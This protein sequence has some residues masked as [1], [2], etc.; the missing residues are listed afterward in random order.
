MHL[1][2]W[3]SQSM[4]ICSILWST[5][6]QLT[7]EELLTTMGLFNLGKSKDSGVEE[8]IPETTRRLRDLIQDYDIGHRSNL[9]NKKR[10]NLT[11]NTAK[12]TILWMIVCIAGNVIQVRNISIQ[13]FRFGIES[14]VQ[15]VVE[16]KIAT[17]SI[18]LCF[19]VPYILK[20][21]E[22]THEDRLAILKF[23][24]LGDQVKTNILDEYQVDN[25]TVKSV[26]ELPQMVKDQADIALK[27]MMTA[28]LQSFD[29]SWIFNHTHRLDDLLK[30]GLLYTEHWPD[31]EGESSHVHVLMASRFQKFKQ[32]FKKLKPSPNTNT[33]NVTKKVSK[34]SNKYEKPI[35]ASIDQLVNVT[36]FFKDVL[37]C[38]NLNMKKEFRDF[39]YYQVMRQATV[40]G[41]LSLF[42]LNQARLKDTREL[43]YVLTP[44][45]RMMKSGFYSFSALSIE[46]MRQF[47][48]TW[49]TYEAELLEAPF[50]TE[51]LDYK[52]ATGFQSKGDCFETCFR[53]YTMNEEIFNET[54]RT[55]NGPNILE[56]EDVR[57]V[58]VGS[59]CHDKKVQS[60]RR[61][62]ELSCNRKCSAKDCLSIV[63][64]PK[65]LS[66]RKTPKHTT[67]VTLAPQTP[68]V[69]AF[70]VPSMSLTNYLTDV[71][72]TFGFWMGISAF[73]FFRSLKF[74]SNT[75]T[76]AYLIDPE[77]LKRR[78]RKRKARLPNMRVPYKDR[79][80]A[81]NPYETSNS[82]D[83]L[84]LKYVIGLQNKSQSHFNY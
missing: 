10:I 66:S 3:V 5:R 81:F 28:N 67:I 39:R 6:Y 27:L 56:G 74:T 24:S 23:G 41:L 53:N 43:M 37:K 32:F 70:C 2:S 72:A 50:E 7:F 29:L 82:Y 73:A 22:M 4:R 40:A 14:N 38:F 15:L 54:G 71:V 13:Y 26:K 78:Q 52:K 77:E 62:A 60:M 83:D 48:M 16:D 12:L 18:T 1:H 65:K 25:E 42:T 11:P 21:N 79:H 69:K 47:I 57:V 44:A 59:Y 51:C 36:T 19:E 9:K 33:S 63:H 31:H 55:L 8:E 17:P 49:D 58:H 68:S 75:F 34:T 64:I 20:W 35:F 84:L 80:P 30:S 61:R 76:R 46:S 45:D